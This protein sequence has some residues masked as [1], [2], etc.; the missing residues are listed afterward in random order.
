MTIVSLNGELA[1]VIVAFYVMQNQGFFSVT[2]IKY[3]AR[4][5]SDA[6]YFSGGDR[7]DEEI[8]PK[9]DFIA[10]FDAVKHLQNINTNTVKPFFAKYA[11][12]IYAK[13]S[14]FIG[15]LLSSGLIK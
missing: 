1:W 7:S 12:D 13:H 5:E 4:L 3:K 10:I 9:E 8:I 2:K 14:P 15:L 11:K 6:I